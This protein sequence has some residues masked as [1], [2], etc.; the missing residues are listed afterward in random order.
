MPWTPAGNLSAA[1]KANHA[2]E[3]DKRNEAWGKTKA[4][5]WKEKVCNV[6]DLEQN[7]SK[8]NSEPSTSSSQSSTSKDNNK[9]QKM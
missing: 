7:V 6:L 2:K 1:K 4:K 8:I 9:S 3:V 5:E